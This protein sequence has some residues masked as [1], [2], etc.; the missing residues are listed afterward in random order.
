MRV[1]ALE[2]A[3]H[4]RLD[5][6]FLSACERNVLLPRR[7]RIASPARWTQ[8]LKVL[9]SSP[10]APTQAE[11]ALPQV[12]DGTRHRLHTVAMRHAFR[13][14]SGCS[15]TER[16][17][18]PSVRATQGTNRVFINHKSCAAGAVSGIGSLRDR[19]WSGGLRR[20]RYAYTRAVEERGMQNGSPRRRGAGTLIHDYALP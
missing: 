15:S 2:H 3:F 10:S 7:T 5:C 13:G 11:S 17:S 8:N 16:A 19:K 12:E 9:D 14:E 20:P 1:V 4:H 6:S 18:L